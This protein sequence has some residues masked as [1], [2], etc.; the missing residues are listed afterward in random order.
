MNVEAAYLHEL[1]ESK[2]IPIP[3]D[4][5]R[6]KTARGRA[7]L[8]LAAI[9]EGQFPERPEASKCKR[10]DMRSICKDAEVGKYDV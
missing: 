6:Q 5:V 3:V 8:L 4:S 7:D 2:R 9:A 10:C 1:K